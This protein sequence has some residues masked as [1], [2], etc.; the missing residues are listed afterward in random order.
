MEGEPVVTVKDYGELEIVK[1]KDPKSNHIS[2]V[3]PPV[4]SA[5][6]LASTLGGVKYD[7][8]SYSSTFRYLV[9]EVKSKNPKLS[10]AYTISYS[11]GERQ[12]YL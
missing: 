4:K 3:I 9:V 11:S 12:T 6:T 10:T 7:A 5:E 8:F 1:E 2:I